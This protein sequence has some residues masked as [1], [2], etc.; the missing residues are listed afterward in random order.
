MLNYHGNYCNPLDLNGKLVPCLQYADDIVLL[1]ESAQGLQN[2]LNK[3]KICDKWNL[4]VN[5][6]KS[7]VMIFNKSGKILK[8]HNFL[9]DG[10]T[11]SLVNEYRCLGII[12]KPSGSFT[13]AIN[14]LAKKFSKAFFCIRKSL[15]SENMNVVLHMKLFDSCVKPILLYWSEI[16]AMSLIVKDGI[17]IETKYDSFHPNRIQI[18]LAKYILGVHKSAINI[19]VLGELG[20]YPLSI[21]SLKSCINYWLYLVNTQEN[22][23]VFYSYKENILL[24]DG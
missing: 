12:F 7:K 17:D 11:V 3:L 19:A 13:E 4:H 20:L 24:K 10:N 6:N 2:L 5:I 14:Q 8:G 18:K 1:S 15:C 23:L 9:Y 22:S 21:Q 16:W